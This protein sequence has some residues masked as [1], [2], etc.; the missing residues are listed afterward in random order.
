MRLLK[1]ISFRGAR[2]FVQV[3]LFILEG[4]V[5]VCDWLAGRVITVF[6]KPE[7][8]RRGACQKTG[9]CCR[10]IGMELPRSWYRHAWVISLVKKWH[11]LRYN[12]TCLGTFGN[13]LV[14]ECNYVTDDNRCGIYPVRPKLCRDFPKR[15]LSG[16]TRL[17]KGCGYAFYRRK[18]TPFDRVLTRMAARRAQLENLGFEV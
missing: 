16:Y 14:Y 3:A 13:M 7:Y 11:Y 10:A 8:V 12:F 17:H 1:R 2:F 6:K 9:Q 15:T 18:A 4:F 5:G